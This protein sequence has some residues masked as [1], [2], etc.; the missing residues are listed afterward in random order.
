MAAR[1]LGS[2]PDDLD[3]LESHRLEADAHAL[4]SPGGDAFALVDQ[5]EEDVLGADVVVVQQA[6]FFLGQ[7]HDPACPIGKPFEQAATS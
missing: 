6:R 4:E 5:A 1:G 2:L 3:D 7:N